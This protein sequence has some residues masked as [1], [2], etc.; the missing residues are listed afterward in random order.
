MTDVMTAAQRS[1]C[2]SRIRSTRT[3]PELTLRRALSARG[4]RYRVKNRLIGRPDIVFTRARIAVFVDGCFWHGCP[5]HGTKPKSNPAYWH[6][7]IERNQVRDRVVTETLKGDGWLVLRYWDHELKDSLDWVAD[8]V[9]EAWAAR[10]YAQ[11]RS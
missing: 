4:L 8:A 10:R 9:A 11:A 3:K 7:K 1:R 2:M 6:P 5:I